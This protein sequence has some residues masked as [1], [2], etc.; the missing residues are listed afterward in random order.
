MGETE[1]EEHD[2]LRGGVARP[3]PRQAARLTGARHTDAAGGVVA[4]RVV[5][6]AASSLGSAAALRQRLDDL[7]REIVVASDVA[8]IKRLNDQLAV[9]RTWARRMQL[10]FDGQNR[11]A[12]LE[13]RSARRLGELLAETV[14]QGRPR[15]ESTQSTVSGYPKGLPEGITR[16]RSSK[17]QRI[18]AIDED[19]FE[20]FL[21]VCKQDGHRI[22]EARLLRVLGRRSAAIR[23]STKKQRVAARFLP[24]SVL[25]RVTRLMDVD[26]VVGDEVQT[27]AGACVV[28]AKRLATD[29]LHGD[30]F[31]GECPDPKRW[32]EGLAVHCRAEAC[33]Q[34]V[35]ALPVATQARW[36]KQIELHGWSC[37][38][39]RDVE[40][41]LAYS[42]RRRHG[43]W[44]A[45]Q[46]VGTVLHGHAY[47]PRDGELEDF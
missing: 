45:F 3:E 13:L 26:V 35:V 1:S 4:G 11:F 44:A 16:D 47:D 12:E 10:A 42:G 2:G 17:C 25:E 22:S 33:N 38:F 29:A 8:S 19:A 32:L 6:G 27:F 34:V 7:Q 23:A 9:A 24:A 43:F 20:E 37:C 18:A 36:F 28:A 30:V 14:R 40:V 15:K 21:E 41:L 39:L 31:V 46:D 5:A